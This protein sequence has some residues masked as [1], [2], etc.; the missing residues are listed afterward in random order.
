MAEAFDA[1]LYG[2]AAGIA[3][4]PR[5]VLAQGDLLQL[6]VWHSKTRWPWTGRRVITSFSKQFLQT[7][8]G[9]ELRLGH[10]IN[11]T[12]RITAVFVSTRQQ[13]AQRLRQ[14]A[15]PKDQQVQHVAHQ[16]T[17][18]SY[19][20]QHLADYTQL[21]QQAQGPDFAVVDLTQ[22]VKTELFAAYDELSA[23]HLS[24]DLSALTEKLSWTSDPR[25]LQ[26]ILQ[27]LI[28]NW[29]K[30]AAGQLR[31]T[32]KQPDAEHAVITFANQVAGPLP[33]VW[34]LTERFYTGDLARQDSSGLG[35]SIVQ[36]LMVSLNG[37]LRLSAEVG[38]FTVTLQFRQELP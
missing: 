1:A 20:L 17:S 30:Y 24:L 38:W 13:Q 15:A 22:V 33:D 8:N 4:D 25:R 37:Q 34:R 26:R 18:V 5:G 29:L 12:G 2:V 19:Y 35:L 7:P 23:H 3:L 36:A 27:N 16:L 28:G 6:L 32:V 9:A 21:Q 10:S 11:M 14:Q 31:V